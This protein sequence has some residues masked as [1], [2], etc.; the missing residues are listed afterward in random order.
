VSNMSGAAPHK[1]SSLLTTRPLYRV[2][3]RHLGAVP[4]S[5]ATC[6]HN[7]IGINMAASPRDKATASSICLRRTKS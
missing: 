3:R 1:T 5:R 7:C 4:A 6:L 2:R